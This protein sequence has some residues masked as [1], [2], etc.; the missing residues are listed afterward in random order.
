M[1]RGVLAVFSDTAVEQWLT[2][3]GPCSWMIMIDPASAERE[4]E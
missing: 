2:T 4:R 3:E 1:R